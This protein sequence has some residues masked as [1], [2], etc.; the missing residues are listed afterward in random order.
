M[1]RFAYAIFCDD[2]RYEVN[3]KS[4]FMGILGNLMYIASFPAILPKLCVA[5]T[6]NTSVDAPFSTLSFKGNIGENVLFEVDLDKSQVALA[7]QNQ[8]L[9]DDPKG[10]MAQ[11]IVVLSPLHIQAPG[12]LQISVIADGKEIECGGMQISQA[13]EEMIIL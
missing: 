1:N 4:S 6:A 7:N 10:F 12:K 3:N 13:P 2:I 5:I 8:G 11:A 9:I